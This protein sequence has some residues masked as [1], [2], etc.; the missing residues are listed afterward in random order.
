MR[1]SVMLLCL[2]CLLLC[3][4]IVSIGRPHH[5]AAELQI[6]RDPAITGLPRPGKLV[7]TADP[8]AASVPDSSPDAMALIQQ[9]K[10]ALNSG[11]P[12]DQEIIFTNQLL[13]LIKT[14]PWVAAHFA[15]SLPA[16]L[17]RTDVMRVIV[18]N[19][20]KSDPGDAAKWVSQLADSNDRD[21]ML[22]CLCFQIAQADPK[23]A[24]QILEQ[25]GIEGDRRKVM[26]GNLAQQLAS[27]DLPGALAW[28]GNYAGADKDDLVAQIALAESKIDPAESA[29]IV[30]RQISPGTVQ[31]ETALSIIN[32]WSQT[33]VAAV[34]SWVA[35]FPAGELHDQ[36]VAQINRVAACS[37]A[38]SN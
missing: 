22:S 15:E 2:G 26:L 30:A 34:T 18:Q 20:S 28:A 25:Q 36:A 10:D 32:Q 24:I 5:R 9:I 6:D 23:S 14:G 16:G 8:P 21:T 35:E 17:S 11:N 4:V 29:L 7:L 3:G 27:Q 38:Q 12:G 33:D 37:N 31:N 19:W 1:T 13:A